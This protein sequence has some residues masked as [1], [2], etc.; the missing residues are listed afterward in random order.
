MPLTAA[1]IL[2]TD[3]SCPDSATASASSPTALLVGRVHDAEAGGPALVVVRGD[4]CHDI[5]ALGPTMS[6]LLSRDDLVTAV[7]NSAGGASWSLD[8]LLSGVD[9]DGTRLLSPIDLQVIKA[10]GVTFAK[11]MLERV[12]EEQAKG[13]PQLARGIRQRLAASLGSKLTDVRAG[14]PEA[15]EVKQVLMDEGLWSQYLEVG[16]GPDPEIFTKAPVLASVGAGAQVG[17]LERSVWNN[18]EPEVVLAVTGAG[19]VVGATLGNDV[20]LRDF[21]GR[22][23]L[24]LAEAKDNNASCAIG[25]FIRLFDEAFSMDDVR[26][27]TVAMEI[28]GA[29]DGFTLAAQSSLTEMSRDPEVL[30]QHAYGRHHQYPDGFVLFTGTMFAPTEDRDAEGEGFTHHAGDVVTIS[31]PALGALVN[32]VGPAEAAPEWTFGI[33]AFMRNLASRGLLG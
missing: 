23:A 4:R 18:P 22:S 28:T 29:D 8:E 26:R 24:L 10:A 13:D 5:T 14:S 9:G 2:P 33:G 16:I 17:V 3:G 7:Q 21:E 1:D 11:S 19:R 32:T 27:L 31:T 25:P 20:N 6:D 30:V 12:I 15:Q